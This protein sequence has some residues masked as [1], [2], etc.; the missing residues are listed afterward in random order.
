MISQVVL[1]IEGYSTSTKERDAICCFLDFQE[2]GEEP[3]N[4]QKLE[5]EWRVSRHVAQSESANALS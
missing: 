1:A 2:M 3:K 5:I 4:T